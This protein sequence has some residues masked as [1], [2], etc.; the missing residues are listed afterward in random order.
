M[1]A[2][3]RVHAAPKAAGKVLRFEIDMADEIAA[4]RFDPARDSVVLMGAVQPLS[5]SSGV[6][7]RAIG[8]QRSGQ[9]FGA[10]VTFDRL[11]AGGQGIQHKARI[12]R[13]GAAGDAGWEAGRNHVAD[14]ATGTVRRRFGAPAAPAPTRLTGTVLPL[15]VPSRHVAGPRPVWVWLPPAYDQHPQQRYPVLVLH[16]GQNV[17]DAA[18]AGAEWQVDE[19]AQQ[20][21]LSGRLRPFIVVAVESGPDRI[22]D[23]TPSAALPDPGSKADA[24]AG[25]RGGGLSSYGRF[26]ADELKPAI[27]ARFRTLAGREHLAVGGSSLGGLAS[28]ALALQPNSPYGAALVVS[29]SVWWDDGWALRAVQ[30]WPVRP[31]PPDVTTQAAGVGAVAPPPARPRLW[32]D[33]GAHEAADAGVQDVRRLRDALVARGWRQGLDLAYVEDPNGGHDEASWSARVPKMLNFLYPNPHHLE[34]RR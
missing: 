23:L 8:S 6:A 20:G 5:W 31:A 25:R 18:A 19:A 1:A 33:I 10:T 14:P 11:P 32:L 30:G 13:P 22:V 21:V 3:Q 26:L 24:G 9:V 34:N 27:D 2:A 15:Q 12:L 17:F 16:D 29:P 28:L 4:G 7:M